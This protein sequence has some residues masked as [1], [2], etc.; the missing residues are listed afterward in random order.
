[1]EWHDIWAGLWDK[2]KNVPLKNLDLD[3]ENQFV[4]Y[5][6]EY[7]MDFGREDKDLDEEKSR[8]STGFIE[9][10]GIIRY[11]PWV[12]HADLVYM[13]DGNVRFLQ[14]NHKNLIKQIYVNE[15]NS[16][17]VVEEHLF[18]HGRKGTYR[19]RE[20]GHEKNN[21]WYYSSQD[22]RT[23]E[24]Y[25]KPK[26]RNYP[27]FHCRLPEKHYSSENI[28]LFEI[29]NNSRKTDKFL[30]KEDIEGNFTTPDKTYKRRFTQTA[31]YNMIYKNLIQS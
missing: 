31:R 29:L 10:G 3:S 27:V 4:D 19:H 20:F 7:L 17:A 2:I 6:K 22:G 30:R 1:M 11:G 15:D 16:I 21:L 9:H 14:K 8:N 13:K 18:K 25:I 5:H 12:A 24:F 23:L 28:D 26:R